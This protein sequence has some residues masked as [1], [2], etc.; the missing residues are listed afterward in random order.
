MTENPY[1][2]ALRPRTIPNEAT[3][4]LLL[5]AFLFM[6]IGSIRG[7]DDNLITLK[8]KL[9]AQNL[10]DACNKLSYDSAKII[11]DAINTYIDFNSILKYWG[12]P[13]EPDDRPIYILDAAGNYEYNYIRYFND[14]NNAASYIPVNGSF[15]GSDFFESATMIKTYNDLEPLSEKIIW[16]TSNAYDTNIINGIE[17]Y[18]PLDYERESMKPVSQPLYYDP[19]VTALGVDLTNENAKEFLN[20]TP[21]GKLKN[22]NPYK[23]QYLANQFSEMKYQYNNDKNYGLTEDELY[24]TVL[25]FYAGFNDRDMRRKSGTYLSAKRIWNKN[26]YT[27]T[28]N[29][30]TTATFE[31]FKDTVESKLPKNKRYSD[32]WPDFGKQKYL[33]NNLLTDNSLVISLPFIEFAVSYQDYAYADEQGSRRIAQKKDPRIYS[34]FGS[35]LYYGQNGNKLAKAFLFLH[36]IPW[37]GVTALEDDADMFNDVYST[38]DTVN[39][40]ML[41]TDTEAFIKAPELWIAFI[42]GILWRYEEVQD[43]ITWTYNNES[44]IPRQWSDGLQEWRTA[45]IPRTWQY[46]Y[47]L[48]TPGRQFGISFTNQ[49]QKIGDLFY[50]HYKRVDSNLRNLPESVKTKFIEYFKNWAENTFE[51]IRPK[52]EI[53]KE[54]N[55]L[56]AF[57]AL[58]ANVIT[59]NELNKDKVKSLKYNAYGIDGFKEN[60]LYN[61]I[62]VSPII[63]E[64]LRKNQTTPEISDANFYLELRDYLSAPNGA[65]GR[66]V[67]WFKKTV[68]IHNPNPYTFNYYRRSSKVFVSKDDMK[69]FLTSFLN[70]F[71]QLTKDGNI[72]RKNEEKALQK[73]I[74]NTTDEDLIKLSIYRTLSSVYDKWVG[75]TNGEVFNQ[76]GVNASDIEISKKEKNSD[77][78]SLID[79]FRF[80]DR[81]FNNIGDKFYINPVAFNTYMRNDY[82]KSL[83]EIINKLLSDNNFNFIPLPNFVNFNEP[84]ELANVF[85][86]YPWIEYADNGASVGPAFVCVYVGQTST[87]LDLGEDSNYPDDG[88]YIDIE[89]GEISIDSANAASDFNNAVIPGNGDMHVPIFAVNYGQQNQNFFK[90]IKLDQREFTETAESL[91]I[92]EDIS[93]AGNE[94]KAVYGG[95]NLFNVYQKR[96]YSAEVEMMGNAVIQPMMYFQLSNIPMFRGMYLIIKVNHS[97]KANSMKTTFKGVRV[98]KTKTPL[99]DRATLFMKLLGDLNPLSIE[100]I[101]SKKNITQNAELFK[102]QYVT[103]NALKNKANLQTGFINILLGA[104]TDNDLPD[105]IKDYVDVKDTS[106]E[107]RYGMFEVIRAVQRVAY[108][109]NLWWETQNKIIITDGVQTSTTDKNTGIYKLRIN[110]ISKLGGGIIGK[111]M[112]HQLGT[113]V[114]ITPIRIDG[115]FQGVTIDNPEYDRVSTRKLAELFMEEKYE[116][117]NVGEIDVDEEPAVDVIYFNDASIYTDSGTGVPG[118]NPLKDHDNHLHVR[119]NIPKRAIEESQGYVMNSRGFGLNPPPRSV[120]E[121]GTG[122][123][124][125]L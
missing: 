94:K 53:M 104:K 112:S 17:F 20:K 106:V 15:D 69:L 48:D 45:Q 57:S 93:D 80:L 55:D 65:M 60:I 24:S 43:P 26:P 121:F 78:T 89:S 39:L 67:N 34:L 87:G 59:E 71:K 74:F 100:E 85:K 62:Y 118:V 61:Y 32:F 47:S 125:T 116:A 77:T 63:P 101:E 10:I 51:P 122:P 49:Q 115:K 18:S 102:Y 12:A 90:N 83:F 98:K 88:I 6:G 91:Q 29:E 92:I 33:M 25:A 31:I 56:R 46:L 96:S 35:S 7:Y 9:E 11:T 68:Y 50:P 95:Q 5:R 16:A 76:C 37:N 84:T 36:T 2:T 107:G 58:Y 109:F 124:A 52:L 120:N 30:F 44:L 3:R 23:G 1:T 117:Y 38:D 21:S 41:F 75:G 14:D 103:R 86:P 99:L 4:V 114:D 28:K 54:G 108:K 8:G 110:D 113:D 27:I 79:S 111:H 73:E 13:T 123:A 66:V 82:N 119:F 19:E 72:A 40:K 64:Y 22:L 81:A 42:G 105:N 97:I 70:E